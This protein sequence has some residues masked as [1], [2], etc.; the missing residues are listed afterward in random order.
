MKWKQWPEK[1]VLLCLLLFALFIPDH[2]WWSVGVVISV[3]GGLAFNFF[4]RYYEDK[5][6]E[7]DED[8][9]FGVFVWMLVIG[10]FVCVCI[11]VGIFMLSTHNKETPSVAAMLSVVDMALFLVSS[12]VF[13]LLHN[14]AAPE[15]VAS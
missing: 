3:F 1:M 8:S 7:K 2:R 10:A 9:A 5:A 14:R 6:Y 15:S 12:L 4:V 13:R 11:I